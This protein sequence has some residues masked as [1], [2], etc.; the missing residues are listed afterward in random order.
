MSPCVNMD[1][2][3][4]R[5]KVTCPQSSSQWVMELRFK[6]RFY[7]LQTPRSFL[8]SPHSQKSFPLQHNVQKPLQGYGPFMNGLHPTFLAP[9]LL[10]SPSL[11]ELLPQPATFS[12]DT[13]LLQ[14]C[15]S[16]LFL[17]LPLSPP[18]KL[19]FILQDPAQMSSQCES[20]L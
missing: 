8:L 12:Q 4:Q 1:A 17:Y 16:L 14:S 3:T 7:P 20:F 5:G 15:F 10:A 18:G 13:E 6:I 11:S 2:E 19:L 9:S